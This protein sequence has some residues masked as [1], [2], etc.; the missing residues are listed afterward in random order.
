MFLMY[1]PDDADVTGSREGDF[2]GIGSM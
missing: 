2:E 1:L